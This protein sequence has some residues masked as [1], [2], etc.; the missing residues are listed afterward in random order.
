MKNLK[1][2]LIAFGILSTVV[3]STTPVLAT[4]NPNTSNNNKTVIATTIMQ[5]SFNYGPNGG[6][7]AGTIIS[8]GGVIQLGDI[9]QAVKDVQDG[10]IARG[11][12]PRTASS[13]DGIFGSKT[14]TAVINFQKSR[15][16]TQDGIVVYKLGLL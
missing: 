9:G 13:M 10:L 16:L 14:K 3:I 6:P 4:T 2:K 5:P 11:F 7:D 8:N 15:T 1:L 12:L